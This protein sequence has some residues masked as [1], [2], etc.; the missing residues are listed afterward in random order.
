MHFNFCSL[1]STLTVSHVL[2]QT[3]IAKHESN[4]IDIIIAL[5]VNSINPLGKNR[6]DLV[7]ELKVSSRCLSERSPTMTHSLHYRNTYNLL[8]KLR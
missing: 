4:G 6:L 8:Y 7:L 2:L 1:Y 3:C 5:I